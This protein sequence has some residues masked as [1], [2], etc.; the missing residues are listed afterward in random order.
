MPS[1]IYNV[2]KLVPKQGK[3]NEI[4]EAFK[5]LSKYI[6]EHEPKTQIYFALQPQGTEEFVFVE[7]YTDAANLKE[8]AS[9]PAFKKFSKSLAGCLAQAPEIKRADFIGGFEGRAKL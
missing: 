9:S 3:F 6:E 4:A 8:H 7:K 2:V 5:A 1:S